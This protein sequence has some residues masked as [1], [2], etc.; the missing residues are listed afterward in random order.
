ML[1]AYAAGLGFVLRSSLTVYSIAIA[2][3]VLE[4]VLIL[5]YVA[6]ETNAPAA[7]TWG[8]IAALFVIQQVVVFGRVYLRVAMIG[9]ERL[10]YEKAR[11]VPAVA[12]VEPSQSEPFVPADPAGLEAQP[13]T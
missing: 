3:L 9:A 10:F 2:I 4:I 5:C 7:G 11:P 12:V 13:T 8:A 6:Y 1:K